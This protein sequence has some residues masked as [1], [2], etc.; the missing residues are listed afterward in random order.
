[1]FVSNVLTCMWNTLS[2]DIKLSVDVN[3]FKKMLK[4]RELQVLKLRAA[5]T[6][7]YVML[8]IIIWYI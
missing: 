3:V 2:P 7:V 1:M 5:N 8:F 6:V 4:T